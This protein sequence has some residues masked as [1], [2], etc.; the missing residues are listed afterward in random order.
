MNYLRI[1]MKIIFFSSLSYFSFTFLRNYNSSENIEKRCL[2][3]FERD[4]NN[5]LESSSEELDQ[6]LDLADNNY[7]KCI[8]VNLY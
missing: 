1:A 3:K 4:F 5:P 2:L 6:L 7:F 8:G